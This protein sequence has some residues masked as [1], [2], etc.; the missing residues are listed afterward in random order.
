MSLSQNPGI[1]LLKFIWW[2]YP[3]P[4]NITGMHISER[5]C[6]T[7]APAS[8]NGSQKKIRCP[9]AS[10][11]HSSKLVLSF[12]DLEAFHSQ[13]FHLSKSPFTPPSAKEVLLAAKFCRLEYTH[14][15]IAVWTTTPVTGFHMDACSLE[16]DEKLHTLYCG[17]FMEF[18]HI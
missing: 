8:L 12:K 14:R 13:A 1:W 9:K 18:L 3:R 6:F 17:L 5:L 2:C 10:V 4:S 7:K 16:E 11:L 15:R